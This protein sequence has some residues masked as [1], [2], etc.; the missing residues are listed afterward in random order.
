M[1][2]VGEGATLSAVR[3]DNGAILTI[4]DDA[5]ELRTLSAARL[6][7]CPN[8]G[9]VLLYKNGPVR[10]PHFAH[11]DVN[12]CT[13]ADRE[14]ET[15]AHRLGK[16]RL[17]QHFRVGAREAALERHL[18]ATDQR[19]DCYI[20]TAD[21]TRFALEF[22]QAN[23]S[24]EHWLERHALYAGQGVRDHW[25]LGQVRYM[26]SITQPPRPISPYEPLPLPRDAYEAAAG[27]FRVREMEKAMLTLS[28]R[29]IYLDPDA[30]V[31]TILLSR[32]QTGG[33]MRAYRFR[34]PLAE[35]ALRGGTLWTPLEPLLTEYEA[36]RRRAVR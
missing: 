11:F 31:L 24:Y 4:A 8:C 14:P 33:L 10:L 19:A 32:G 36:A 22:Q 27:S 3:A 34:V 7:R 21:S 26:E 16:F 20:V 6:L 28:D 13:Y 12:T 1:A 17:F 5:A 2:G 29:L 23:N 35:A 9:G 18:S 15:E 30:E 25:F